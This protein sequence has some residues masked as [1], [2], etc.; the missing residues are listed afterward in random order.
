MDQESKLRRKAQASHVPAA[1]VLRRLGANLREARVARD[2]TLLDAAKR[3]EISVQTLRALEAG[4]PG[5]KIETLARMLWQMNLLSQLGAVAERQ[6][7]EEGQ[8][9]AALRAPARARG[10]LVQSSAQKATWASVG[11]DSI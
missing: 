10:T 1:E 4:A 8:R 6:S 3:A 9:L 11:I 5:V 7:D 2:I